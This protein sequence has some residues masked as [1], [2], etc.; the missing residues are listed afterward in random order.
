MRTA[1]A[2]TVDVPVPTGWRVGVA[3][4]TA[5]AAAVLTA[6]TLAETPDLSPTWFAGL[7][8]SGGMCLILALR[9]VW[10]Q[11]CRL[12]WD[13]EQWLIGGA[14][15]PDE[16]LRPGRLRVMLDLSSAMLLRFDAAGQGHHVV[17]WIPVSHA[18]LGA[19]WPAWR[20]TVYSA[21]QIPP[22]APTRPEPHE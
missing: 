17:C 19:R 4:L 2:L 12:R 1:P 10:L 9:L 13:G 20:L 6:W 16:Q 3:G 7:A 11:P 8:V 5:L 22:I 15:A 14:G 18:G 21:P